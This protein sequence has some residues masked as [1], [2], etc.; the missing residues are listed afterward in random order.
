MEA[1]AAA[2]KPAPSVIDRAV[3]EAFLFEEA[4]LLD[5]RRFRDWMALF[6]ED[7]TYW[8]PATA[9]QQS[10]FDQVSLFYDDRGLMKTRVDR[11]QHPRI[12]IQT[13]PSRTAHLVGNVI[14]DEADD[15][16]GRYVVSSTVIMVEYR[17]DQQRI[18]AGRQIHTL[19]RSGDG[20]SIVQKRVNL[21]NCDSAFEAMAVPI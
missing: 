13:P 20:F 10:P 7:G 5:A 18:F 2:S 16:K 19:R 15:A 11:L 9:D 8:V 14:V 3:F 21:V 17:D 6:A 12:H 1:A 4:R